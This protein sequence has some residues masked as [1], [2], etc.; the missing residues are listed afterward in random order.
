MALMV[1]Y[2]ISSNIKVKPFYWSDGE[3]VPSNV[4]CYPFAVMRHAAPRY[5]LE[6]DDV[7]NHKTSYSIFIYILYLVPKGRSKGHFIDAGI[8]LCQ[9]SPA[10][11]I[12]GG[13]LI[14]EGSFMKLK[15]QHILLI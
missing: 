13:K 11:F 9:Q 6:C 14:K 10:S 1:S 2:W 5:S 12:N 3:I 8:E 7:P 15:L 4:E